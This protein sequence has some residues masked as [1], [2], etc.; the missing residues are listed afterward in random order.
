MNLRTRIARVEQLHAANAKTDV[1]IEKE[2]VRL[3]ADGNS[4]IRDRAMVSPL[5]A[6]LLLRRQQP[7]QALK[8]LH[9]ADTIQLRIRS[10]SRESVHQGKIGIRNPF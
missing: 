4:Q 5:S 10:R 2:L 1:E 9:Q 8:S 7:S 3:R 6:L